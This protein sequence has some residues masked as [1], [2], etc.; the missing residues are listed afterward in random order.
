MIMSTPGTAAIAS[1][2]S[3]AAGSSIWIST[4]VCSLACRT[5]SAIGSKAYGASAPAPSNPRCPIGANFDH[6][7]TSRASAASE[8]RGYMMP[9]APDSSSRPIRMNSPLPGRAMM[10]VPRPPARAARIRLAAVSTL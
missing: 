5:Y 6:R 10:S 8:Q 1:A 3:S 2:S 9:V 7:T 4:N